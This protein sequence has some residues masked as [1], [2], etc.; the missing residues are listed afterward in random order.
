[1]STT[2]ADYQLEYSP[3]LS[4]AGLASALGQ[5]LRSGNLM[6]DR[7][8]HYCTGLDDRFRVYAACCPV[9]QWAP[10][11]LLQGDVRSQHELYLP[12]AEI[13][14][15]FAHLCRRSCLYGLDIQSVHL[16]AAPSW[17]DFLARLKLSPYLFNPAEM[18]QRLAM[19]ERFREAFLSAL[20]V[21]RSFGGAFGRYPRQAAFLSAWLADAR[22]R[23]SG[24]AAL[25]DAACGCGESTYEA[26][27]ILLA[28]GYVP[29]LSRVDGSTLEPLEL[30]AA[31]FGYYPGDPRRAAFFKARVGSLLERGGSGMIRFFRED[32]CSPAD[33]DRRYDVIICNGLLGGPLLH[34]EAALARAVGSL[35]GRLKPGGVLLVADCFHQGWKKRQQGELLSLLREC[36][37]ELVEAGEGVGA[38]K[39]DQ[40]AAP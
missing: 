20:F 33:S 28:E 3:E 5:L 22:G 18:L 31:A 35:A 11:M 21:P 40:Q 39:A 9:P 8:R 7:L 24:A 30:L 23:L 4:G 26:G 29:R 36:G 34:G 6:D 37:L 13:V 2:L 14:P 17:P 25:L 15:A 27:E 38:L 10:G 19:E 1:M 12:M 32:V 16:L